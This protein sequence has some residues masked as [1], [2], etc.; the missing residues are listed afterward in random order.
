MQNELDSCK[1][2]LRSIPPHAPHALHTPALGRD[3]NRDN[4]LKAALK[5]FKAGR[6]THLLQR[7]G[8]ELSFGKRALPGSCG[9]A[10]ILLIRCGAY[11]EHS[12]GR[13]SGSARYR[14]SCRC[15]RDVIRLSPHS[16]LQRLPQN[17]NNERRTR[18]SLKPCKKWTPLRFLSP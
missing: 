6:P 2:E 11:H 14:N 9:L 17:E 8:T 7:H 5:P 1:N 18:N 12:F 16:H 4:P 13:W 10:G 3:N 15:R